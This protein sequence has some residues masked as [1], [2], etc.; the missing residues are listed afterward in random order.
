MNGKKKRFGSAKSLLL[1]TA[2]FAVCDAHA[3]SAL[4]KA[5]LLS[6]RLMNGS[7]YSMDPRVPDHAKLQQ[8]ANLLSSGR[9]LEAARFITSQEQ[10]Y[11]ELLVVQIVN[12]MLYADR[13]NR[14]QTMTDALAMVLGIVR[15]DRRFDSI[16][17]DKGRYTISNSRFTAARNTFNQYSRTGDN[18]LTD[19]VRL[20]AGDTSLGYAIADEDVAGILSTDAWALQYVIGGT[21]RRNIQGLVQLVGMELDDLR[22]TNVSSTFVARDIS[23]VPDSFQPNLFFN[24]CL[25]CHYVIDPQRD[26]FFKFARGNVV[27]PGGAEMTGLVSAANGNGNFAINTNNF[28]SGWVT[29]NN[30]WRNMMTPKVASA[31]GWRGASTGMG[32][33]SLGLA[34]SQS[35]AFY[36][37]IVKRALNQLCP[38]SEVGSKLMESLIREFESNGNFRLMTEKVA[39]LPQCLG[40]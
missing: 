36:R 24:F 33:G 37:A 18:L 12:D 13:S 9:R 16:L 15:D 34:W 21:E 40:G 38:N 39:T 23:R 2:F 28:P 25:T 35:S 4:E 27:L 30:R 22:D 20:E 19:L 5:A 1:I 11:L 8:V 29:T 26:A 10:D 7:G 3:Q 6:A 17:Y 31:F 32:A 14:T